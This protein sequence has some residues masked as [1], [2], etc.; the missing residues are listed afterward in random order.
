MT[1]S[2]EPNTRWE[3]AAAVIRRRALRSRDV[4]VVF[5]LALSGALPLGAQHVGETRA[6]SLRRVMLGVDVSYANFQGAIDPWTTTAISLARRSAWGSIIGR[7]NLANR[8]ATSGSQIEV[9]AYPRTSKTTYLYLNAGYSQSSIFPEWRF[10]GEV[11]ASLPNAWEASLGFRQLRFGGDPVTLYTGTVG[12][13][14]GNF[15][16]SLRPY[17]RFKAGG[18]SASA[19]LT[20][21]RYFEDADNYLGLRASSGSSPTD[22]ITP[23]AIARTNSSSF[24]VHG[25]HALSARYLWNWSAGRDQEQLSAT[26]TRTSLTASVGI[27]YVF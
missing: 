1:T 11:F 3:V 22:N 10:G 24:G 20:L 13:Y 16:A 25:S 9:D 17:V 27:K 4:V 5:V 12:H 15:W 26:N 7:A 6:D 19:G 2:T 8:F 18:S 23:D 14:F 21:R